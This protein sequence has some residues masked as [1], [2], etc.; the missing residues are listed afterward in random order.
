VCRIGAR[1]ERKVTGQLVNAFK[2]VSGKEN[3]LFKLAVGVAHR[4]GGHGP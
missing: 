4:T 2:K 3:I 1:A